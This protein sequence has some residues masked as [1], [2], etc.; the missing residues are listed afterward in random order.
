MVTSDL[1]KQAREILHDKIRRATVG[2]KG[3]HHHLPIN[4]EKPIQENLMRILLEE[5]Q[6]IPDHLMG[7]ETMV[8]PRALDHRMPRK[9]RR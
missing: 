3:N 1:P 2:V 8:Y 4:L 5:A 6:V 9:R 7:M